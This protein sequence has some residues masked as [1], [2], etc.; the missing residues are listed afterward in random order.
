MPLPLYCD[1]HLHLQDQ[2]FAGERADIIDRAI[3]GGVSRMLCNA[4]CE[5]DWQSIIEMGKRYPQVIPFIGLHPWYAG[6]AVSGWE[7]RL[8]AHLQATG[9]GIGEAGLD[10]SCKVDRQLQAKVFM[11]QLDLAVSLGRPLVIHCVRCWGQLI[12]LLSGPLTSGAMPLLMVHSFNGSLEVMQRLINLGCYLSFSAKILHPPDSKIS[13]AFMATPMER[14]LLE[15][16]A[17]DQ[18][19]GAEV[20]QQAR[21][22]PVFIT[23]LYEQA[24]RMRAMDLDTFCKA[25]WDNATVFTRA[26]SA[27]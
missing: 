18:L 14:L 4:V 7:N 24:A 5:E 1:A 25:V 11:Q 26:A 22:E 23:S 27:R 6:R 17:P 20:V 8:A 15:T 9:C 10:R 13:R 2:R 3:S 19:Y 16:D 12:D 21:N